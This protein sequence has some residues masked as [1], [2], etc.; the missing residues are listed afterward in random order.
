MKKIFLLLAVIMNFSTTVGS[1]PTPTLDTSWSGYYERNRVLLEPR[2][3]LLK[4]ATLFQE[5]GA[6]PLFAV[7]LGAGGGRDSAY[8]VSRGWRVIAVDAESTAR[9][10]FFE[11]IPESQKKEANFVVST[12]E[13]FVFPEG[14][15]LINASYALPFCNPA[16]FDAVMQRI[17]HAL[18][19]GGRFSGQFFGMR[20]SWNND[21]SMVFVTKEAIE[22][23][24]QGFEIEYFQEEEKDGPSGSGFKHWHVYHV[25]ARK[26]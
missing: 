13:D 5:E 1:S 9:E 24:F 7:D 17:T 12:F 16:D 14:V 23:Y 2:E 25:V 21:P 8:L 11:S 20:D 19:T 22:R 18:P 4:A 15:K 26:L 10:F 6:S 3:T